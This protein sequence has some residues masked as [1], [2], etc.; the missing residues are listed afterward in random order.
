MPQVPYQPYSEV[1]AQDIAT[2]NVHVSTPEGAFGAGTAQA[3]RRL[4][5]QLQQSG[6]E[7][8]QRALEFK[9]L[10]NQT[11]AR[12]ADMARME[13]AAKAHMD[14]DALPPAEKGGKLQGHIENLKSITKQYRETLTNPM[15]QKYYDAY[16]HADLRHHIFNA[17]GVAGVATRKAAI[18]SGDAQISLLLNG[19]ELDPSDENFGKTIEKVTEVV[20]QTKEAA[21]LT[22]PEVE[23]KTARLISKAVMAKIK[24][25]LK[26]DP[27]GAANAMDQYNHLLR[28]DDY[29][30]IADVVQSRSRVILADRAAID[31]TRDVNDPNKPAPSLEQV[32][33]E[34]TERAKRD[35]PND[36]MAVPQYRRA[37]HQELTRLYAQKKQAENDQRM[38][39]Q[40]N[41]LAH[42][43][44]NTEELLALGPEVRN[45]WDR[46]TE[47]QRKNH[48]DFIY[49]QYKQDRDRPTP[50]RDAM[51]MYL[52]GASKQDLVDTDLTEV[53]DLTF[54][55]RIKLMAKQ[56]QYA[57]TLD[58]DE[59]P[60]VNRAMEQLNSQLV[61]GKTPNLTKDQLQVFKG[62]LQ[63]MIEEH[64]KEN[65]GKPPNREEIARFGK[66]LIMEVIDQSKFLSSIVTRKSYV[67]EMGVTAEQAQK[68]EEGIE[69]GL[70]PRDISEEDKE[71]Y[72]A[73]V[74]ARAAY[75]KLYGK[76]LES[77][78]RR[79]E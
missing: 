74:H 64:I 49:Q 62:R 76:E 72:N 46:L 23:D 79:P 38:T 42:R 27:I 47:A 75:K 4:G 69:K 20:R 40:E 59:D 15:A 35:L 65:N 70:I 54:N 22:P 39:L 18:A 52:W 56:R 34:M 6:D 24:G 61:G 41:I 60:R 37:G 45:I 8:F 58:K 2:P 43:P 36:P 16:G 55:N 67:F 5:A 73:R 68:I 9:D 51:F 1:S 77:P 57:K 48:E 50:Q 44:K 53:K 14:F 17:S 3:V 19:I 32:D 25:I 21:G 30:Q 26:N 63:Y 28:Q 7:L 66:A 78:K 33:K 31:A 71:R 29:N 12:D 10:E 13:K 11:A